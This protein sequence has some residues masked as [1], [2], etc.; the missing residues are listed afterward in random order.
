VEPTCE[1]VT[2]A[3]GHGW[4]FGPFQV[5]VTSERLWRG[6]AA[7]VLRPKSFAVLRYL[8]ARA[9]QLVARYDAIVLWMLGYPDQAL[10]GSRR[11][12][13]LAQEVAQP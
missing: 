13:N 9:G 5:D 3:R 7:I 6:T 1:E 10:E 11:A 2:M 4:Q 8:V 12:L